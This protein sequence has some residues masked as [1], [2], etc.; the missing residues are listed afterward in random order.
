[1]K[2]VIDSDRVTLYQADCLDMLKTLPDD[3]LDSLVTDPPSGIAFMGKDWDRHKGGRDSWIAWLAE[4]MAECYRVLKPGAHGLVWALPRTA[5]WTTT[6]CENAGF[7]IRDVVL[8]LQ[9]QGFP[10]SLT[11]KSAE[12]PEWA[13][14]ALKPASEHWILV[15]K[16]L[17][18]TVSETFAKHGTGVLNIDGCRIEGVLEGEH[19]RY[20]ANV[21]LDEEAAR[22]LDLQS[23]QSKSTKGKPR[24]S[25]APGKGWGMTATGSEYNDSGGA[26]RFYYVA[27]GSRKEKD[28]G[29]DHL[30]VKTGG[31]ATDREDGSDGLKSPRAG[32]GRTGGV[33]NHHP[34]IKSIALM[35]WLI[36]L[37]T[38]PG[39]TVLDPFAGSGTTGVAALKEGM[40]FIG[41]E[42]EEEYVTIA[43]GRI[44]HAQR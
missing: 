23:G 10:K 21:T 6:A 29:L 4:I 39:G 44:E 43:K 27:K 12:I 14:T 13:G 15:R 42:R 36:R 16:P 32:A 34:T 1:M 31:E 19:G 35:T 5:H 11:H 24:G 8:H 37:V 30:P 22:V 25:K 41:C 3:C 9:G 2:T 17:D 20:P 26:S 28:A 33:R 38:P 18:G 7:E 40:S